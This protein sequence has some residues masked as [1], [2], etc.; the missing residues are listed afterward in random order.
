MCVLLAN[1]LPV[2]L[3]ICGRWILDSPS[4]IALKTFSVG[5]DATSFFSFFWQ[6]AKDEDYANSTVGQ[7]KMRGV[8]LMLHACL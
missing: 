1:V 6:L 8:L 4:M 7:S 3:I 2:D 5:R